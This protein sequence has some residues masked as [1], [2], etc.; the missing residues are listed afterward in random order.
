M[1]CI[2]IGGL[3]VNLDGVQGEWSNK[4]ER[5]YSI[6]RPRSVSSSERAFYMK[7]G[8]RSR[9]DKVKCLRYGIILEASTTL[10]YDAPFPPDF[11]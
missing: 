6:G 8:L 1:Q 2:Y 5:S 3:R 7:E 10:N 11:S 9:K 4:I